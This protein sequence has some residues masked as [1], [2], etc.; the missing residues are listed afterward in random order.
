MNSASKFPSQYVLPGDDVSALITNAKS[1]GPLDAVPEISLGN[2]LRQM[3][4]R[5]IV[6]R[7]GQLRH[8]PPSH[9]FVE[10]SYP[11]KL[12]IPKQHDQVIGIIEDRGSEFYRINIFSGS[13][14]NLSRLAFEG[15]S[16][17][18]RPELNKGDLIY[19]QVELVNKDVDVELT[20]ISKSGQKKDWNSGEAVYGELKE[21]L[22]VQLPIGS[23]E[24]L[25]RPDNL[26]VNAL[27]EHLSFEIAIGMN[28]ILWVKGRNETETI[29]IRNAIENSFVLAGQDAKVIAMVEALVKVAKN[30]T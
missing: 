14:A 5:V 3:K 12:Y 23:V 27:G 25:L 24:S 21:G 6:L 28:G 19:T 22:I 9:Y 30:S 8:R 20:C 1:V 13:L 16:K 2:G 29:I 15:A 10:E 4:D 26:V 7:N 11:N 17:R 18:N